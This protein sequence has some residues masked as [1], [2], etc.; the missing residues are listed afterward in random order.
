M[1]FLALTAPYYIRPLYDEKVCFRIPYSL[2]C[3]HT[4]LNITTLDV[5]VGSIFDSNCMKEGIGEIM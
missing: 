5:R 3:V 1:G 2:Y 4:L